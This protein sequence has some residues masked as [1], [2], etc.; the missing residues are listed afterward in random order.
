MKGSIEKLL[1]L[2]ADIII[3]IIVAGVVIGV[4]VSTFGPQILQGLGPGFFG[5]TDQIIYT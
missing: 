3:W 5:T 2:K 4:M 1:G